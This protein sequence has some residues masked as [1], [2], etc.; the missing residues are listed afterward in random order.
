MVRGLFFEHEK[1][2]RNEI[3]EELIR[4]RF[5]GMNVLGVSVQESLDVN[6]ETVLAMASA[7]RSER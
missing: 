4:T 3:A 6:I 5:A 7:P 2:R 1:K